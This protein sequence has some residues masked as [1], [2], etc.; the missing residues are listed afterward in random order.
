M[1]S[2]G[3]YL[4]FLYTMLGNRVPLRT[5]VQ[6]TIE[7]C[8]KM[9]TSS[10]G[11]VTIVSVFVGAVTTIQ[12]S[13]NMDTTFTQNFLIGYG[14]RN[15]VIL[16]LAPTMTALVFAGKVASNIAGQLGAMRISEQIDALEMMGINA[17]NYLALPKIMASVLVYPL[18]VVVAIFLAIYSGYWAVVKILPVAPADYIRGLQ[19]MFDP[20]IIRFCLYKSL[21]FAFLIASI[22][23]YKGFYAWGGAVEV[24]K[25]STQAVTHSCTAV[26]IADYVLTQLLL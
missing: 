12:L 17:S 24:G 22:A 14:V 7:E 11:I 15:M 4:L 26:L 1:Q 21:A 9:G 13:Y 20:Y 5:Y 19:F 3:K 2:L 6:Q 16:E 8:T 25:A 18:L 23:C 10:V